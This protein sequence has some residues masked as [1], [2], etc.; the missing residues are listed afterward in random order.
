MKSNRFPW[1]AS[2][3]KGF[4]QLTS[5]LKTANNGSAMPWRDKP[6]AGLLLLSIHS[7]HALAP[8]LRRGH[9][10]NILQ[11]TMNLLPLL[12]LC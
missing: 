12:L 6:S 1:K 7:N 9:K 5:A 11:A 2:C 10:L 3:E 4:A 8:I